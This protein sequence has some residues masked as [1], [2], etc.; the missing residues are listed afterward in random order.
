MRLMDRMLKETKDLEKEKKRKREQAF[1]DDDEMGMAYMRR[2]RMKPLDTDPGV[3]NQQDETSI[4]TM[5][6]VF[7]RTAIFHTKKEE[8]K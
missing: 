2:E 8:P 3:F 4:N 5:K 7:D 6:S 1:L